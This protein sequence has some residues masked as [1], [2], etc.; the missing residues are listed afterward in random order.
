MSL[1]ISEKRWVNSTALLTVIVLGLLLWAWLAGMVATASLGGDWRSV[2][3]WSLAAILAYYGDSKKV[4]SAAFI[5]ALAGLVPLLGI[6]ALLARP[7]KRSLHGEARFANLRDVTKAGLVATKGQGILLG[8][9]GGRYLT[10]G[11]TQHVLVTAPTRSGKGVSLVIPNLLTWPDSVVVLDI[12]LENYELTSKYRARHGQACFLFAPMASDGHTHRWNALGYVAREP[13]RRVDDVQ[14]IANMLYPDRDDDSP[15]WTATPRAF[16]VGIVLYLLETPGKPVTIGQVLREA[17]TGGDGFE[18]FKAIV[19]ERRNSGSP[20]SDACERALNAYLGI[21]A[22]RTRSGVHAGFVAQLELWQ[23]PLIDAATSTNDF[24]L[25]ELRRRKMSVYLGVAPADLERAGPIVRLFFQQL[26][27]LNTR[28]RPAQDKTLK[29]RCLLLLDEFTA[30]GRIPV[31]AKGIAYLAGYGLRLMP[32]IQSFTQLNEVYGKDAATTLKTNM[33]ATVVFA[34]KPSD[35]EAARD[36]SEALGYTTVKG[37][38]KSRRTEIFTKP[39]PSKSES[40]QRRALLLPQE[41][42][43]LG[44]KTALIMMENVPPIKARKAVYYKDA[45]FIRRLTATWPG[46]RVKRGALVEE[47]VEQAISEGHLA[48]P[49]AAATLATSQPGETFLR[50]QNFAGAADEGGQGNT[51]SLSRALEPEDVFSPRPLH[52]N[53]DYSGVHIPGKAARTEQTM[54]QVGAQFFACMEFA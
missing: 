32:I 3:P 1:A 25:R 45:A 29:Y 36:I 38:S 23:N 12:K 41:V 9:F 7:E 22:D 2:K 17:L 26:I 4:Q 51:L 28:T 33:A 6:G 52:L 43:A 53:V 27:D 46:L 20:L 14:R 8:R 13:G 39:N 54:R 15:I 31:L 11:G 40:D 42:S 19:E 34:P 5:G 18:H 35:V 50:A 49:V 24:D 30:P 48:E 16:F 47:S 10:F 21:T 44:D 37:V